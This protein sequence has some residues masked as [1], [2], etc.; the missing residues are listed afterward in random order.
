M[1]EALIDAAEEE[2]ESRATLGEAERY[3]NPG[4]DARFGG[5]L[6]KLFSDAQ[7]ESAFKS[8]TPP[9]RSVV[10]SEAAGYLREVSFSQPRDLPF[11]GIAKRNA[12]GR[13]DTLRVGWRWDPNWGDAGLKPGS[14]NPDPHIIGGYFFDVILKLNQARP[15]IDPQ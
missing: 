8:S 7:D 5:L 12:A 10:G 15:H 9:R 14:Y 4:P 13:W 1:L 3:V 6:G 2:G 11:I